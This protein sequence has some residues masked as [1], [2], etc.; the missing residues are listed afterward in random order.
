M[1]RALIWL[2]RFSTRQITAPIAHKGDASYF[3]LEAK[4]GP[5]VNAAWSYETPD[6]GLEQIEGHLAFFAD[7][8]TVEQI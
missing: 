8:V 7:K 2:W 4:S 3:T 1:F 5:I 6:E